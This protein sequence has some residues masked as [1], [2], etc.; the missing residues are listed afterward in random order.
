MYQKYG[1]ILLLSVKIMWL[2]LAKSLTQICRTY[3]PRQV[4][5]TLVA[6]LYI[7]ITPNEANIQMKISGVSCFLFSCKRTKK[8]TDLVIIFD[9]NYTHGALGQCQCAK[10]MKGKCDNFKMIWKSFNVICHNQRCHVMSLYTLT[11]NTGSRQEMSNK[12][13]NLFE[14]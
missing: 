13:H 6:I 8:R 1:N 7:Y 4:L 12:Y 11:I 5:C 10:S 2:L 14:L 9:T 3:P